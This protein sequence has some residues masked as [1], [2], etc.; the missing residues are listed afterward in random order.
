MTTEEAEEAGMGVGDRVKGLEEME[1]DV[2][3]RELVDSVESVE[4][5]R[6]LRRKGTDGRRY[7]GKMLGYAWGSLGL[8]KRAMVG[9]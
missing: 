5:W 1:L 8:R 4:D 3:A 6:D 9:M 2:D 7:V